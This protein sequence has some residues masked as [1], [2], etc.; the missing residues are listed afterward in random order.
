MSGLSKSRDGVPIVKVK[1]LLDTNSGAIRNQA[2]LEL[3]EGLALRV[4]ARIRGY[5][6]EQREEYVS[7]GEPLDR[8]HAAVMKSFFSPTFLAGVKVVQ[9]VG[10]RVAEP[11]CCVEARAAG[12][13]GL[14]EF[15]H[16]ASVTFQDVLVFNE[17]ITERLLFQ[18]LVRSVQFQTLGLERYVELLIRSF[19]DTRWLC[20]V[21]LEAHAFELES[22]FA[23]DRKKTFSV[24]DE[25][26]MWVS[27]DRY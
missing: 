24:E 27:Q 20:S 22:R 15:T 19:L 12:F 8:G 26:R 10:R 4:Q 13:Q 2:N 11:S 1:R 3:T 9:L 23:T 6:R 21:P 16:L 5:M 7:I 14:P 17:K 18:A 25:V